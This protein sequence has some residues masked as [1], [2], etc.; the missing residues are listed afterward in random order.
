MSGCPPIFLQYPTDRNYSGDFLRSCY[1]KYLFHYHEQL[2]IVRLSSYYPGSSQEE[3]SGDFISTGREFNHVR[4]SNFKIASKIFQGSRVSFDHL[5]LK[6]YPIFMSSP[7]DGRPDLA[8]TNTARV[9][10]TSEQRDPEDAG[11]EDTSCQP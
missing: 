3:G 7:S 2:T 11:A 5:N 9:E 10:R 1:Q 8:N 6:L 4:F